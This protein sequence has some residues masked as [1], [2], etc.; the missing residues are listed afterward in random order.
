MDEHDD[1]ERALKE[2]A[3]E[4]ELF[5]DIIK[6]LIDSNN[7]KKMN[8]YVDYMSGKLWLS[9]NQFIHSKIYELENSII[10][11]IIKDDISIDYSDLDKKIELYK[12][13]IETYG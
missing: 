1:I 13:T 12:K 5:V 10:S 11:P 6:N 3:L 2:Q 8:E 4:R 9:L 7:I